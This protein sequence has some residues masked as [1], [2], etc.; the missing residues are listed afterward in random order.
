MDSDKSFISFEPISCKKDILGD[1][2]NVLSF[3]DNKD[4]EYISLFDVLSVLRDFNLEFENFKRF[5]SDK[6]NYIAKDKICVN[7]SVILNN[8]DYSNNLL[9]ISFKKYIHYNWTDIYFGKQDGD[10]FIARSNS[11]LNEGILLNLGSCLSDLYDGFLGYYDYNDYSNSK[12][13]IRV[14][15]S[16]FVVD[17]SRYGINVYFRDL[18]TNKSVLRLTGYSY[19]N[20]YEFKCNS[21]VISEVFKDNEEDILRKLFVRIDDCPIW[22]QNRLFKVRLDQLRKGKFLFKVFKKRNVL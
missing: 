6:L 3:D 7:S 14:K 8:F 12:S 9:S 1:V 2:R 20:D 22:C 16:S 10:L 13:S 5:Y 11:C 19:K 18:D 17:V 4:K 21:S 15:N